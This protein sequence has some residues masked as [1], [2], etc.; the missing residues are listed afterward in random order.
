MPYVIY[1]IGV[2]GRGARVSGLFG[3]SC[4]LRSK[5]SVLDYSLVVANVGI[6]GRFSFRFLSVVLRQKIYFVCIMAHACFSNSTCHWA[7]RC[8]VT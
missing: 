5:A 1:L 8:V 6:L 2:G 4:L 7:M 3:F